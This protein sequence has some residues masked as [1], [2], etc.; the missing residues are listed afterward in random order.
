MG[1]RNLCSFQLPNLPHSTYESTCPNEISLYDPAEIGCPIH[2][3]F[4]GLVNPHSWTSA[5]V[6][7]VIDPID[8]LS[9]RREVW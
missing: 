4:V 6:N 8:R 7:Q 9:Q 1:A 5:R 3:Y 2:V